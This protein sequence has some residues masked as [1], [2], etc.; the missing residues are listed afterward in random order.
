MSA[1]NTE[2][3]LE[4]NL[5]SK[6]DALECHF[7]WDL[8]ASRSRLFFIR[9]QL[10]DIGTEDGFSWLGHINNLQ[11]FVHYLLGF[12]EE[13]CRFLHKAT[14]AF[15]QIRNT[16]SDE[17][18]WLVVN[19]GNLAWLHHH[20][21]QQAQSQDYLLKVQ[22]LMSK[23]PPPSQD[24]L[25]PEICAEKAW[26]LMKFDKEK[27][28]QAADYFQRAIRMN[29]DM[30]EWQTSRVLALSN[31]FK[32]NIKDLSDD[33]LG[34]M[35]TAKEHDPNNLYLAAFYLEARAAKGEEVEEDACDLATKVLQKSAGTFS[36]LTALLRLYR[37][38]IS[39]DEAIHLAEE[40]LARDPES[41]FA[42]RC[43]AICY[44]RRIFHERGN[45]ESK[46]MDRAISLCKEVIALYPDSSF[47]IKLNL[48]EIYAKCNVAE[49]DQMFE[50]VLSAAA[51]LEPEDRQML[52]NCYAKH[53][54][55]SRRQSQKSIEYHMKAAEIPQPS[56][57]RYN[58]IKQLE[59]IRD[60]N[61]NWKCGEIKEFLA[62]LPH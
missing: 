38:H 56:R 3:K 53:L 50:D 31:D 24:E 4:S 44:K 28:L 2:S 55:Y 51:D 59:K 29:P 43:V 49:A 7:T 42:K 46:V 17:G 12:H 48:A 40:A 26:T 10:A 1:A 27:R 37:R 47:E 30:V 61:R 16:V 39:M 19:Y 54:H 34:K 23:Y 60:G 21:G 20:L 5:E 22:D 62:K 8:N 36:G 58:S 45:F 35:K 6:L 15:R 57:Y 32:A 33:I 9:D 25:H 14:E 18:P 11:G 52:Y 41:R 13:A